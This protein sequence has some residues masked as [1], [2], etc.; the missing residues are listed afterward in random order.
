MRMFSAGVLKSLL[1]KLAASCAVATAIVS[2]STSAP[3]QLLVPGTGQKLTKVGDDFED[4]KWDYVYNLPKSSEENDNRQRLPGGY[5]KNARWFEGAKRGQPDQVSR[6]PTPP[7]G[8]PGSTG[9]MMMRS[10]QTG[11][12][13]YYSGK[14]EQDDFICNVT[15]R[16][17]GGIS[18]WRQ[19][20]VVVRVH[21][22]P[23][24]EWERRNGPSF[25]FRAACQTHKTE[26]KRGKFGSVSRQVKPE[27]YWPGFFIHFVP[28]DGKDK[29]DYAFFTVRAGAY[30]QDLHGPKIT[31]TG[32]W[33]LGMSFTGDGRVH[34]FAHEGVEPLTAK[35]HISTQYPYSY[36]CER[37]DTLFFNVVSGNNGQW[38]TPW[39]VDDAE[40]YVGR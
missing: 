7:D 24:E 40:L 29:K 34:Y 32:W 3:A 26:T 38:S 20:S 19:P 6:V 18:I 21:I 30:G 13:G 25:G 37:M 39:I 33:T 31:Q 22:P 5:S 15:S 17:G 10:K 12:P 35:D 23:F 14:F 1:K 4:E 16:L 11:V 36:N 9:A 8:L 28:G 2:V 27:T